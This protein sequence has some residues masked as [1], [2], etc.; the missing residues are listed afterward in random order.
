M[1]LRKYS[2]K[3]CVI[4]FGFYSTRF[5]VCIYLPCI[6]TQQQTTA[7]FDE[8]PIISSSD[9]RKIGLYQGSANFCEGDSNSDII[10]L[11]QQYQA[12]HYCNQSSLSIVPDLRIFVF[13]IKIVDLILRS[14]LVQFSLLCASYL[15]NLTGLGCYVYTI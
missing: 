11:I 1:I 2:F 5:K 10:R 13:S 15:Y 8:T 3:V 7:P 14:D 4:S 6:N 9:C 12:I